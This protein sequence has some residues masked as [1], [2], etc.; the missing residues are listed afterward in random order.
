MKTQSD[1]GQLGC[2]HAAVNAAPTVRT[3][4]GAPAQSSLLKMN[5]EGTGGLGAAR[6]QGNMAAAEGRSVT[7]CLR[8][9]G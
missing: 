2:E 7:Q 6:G 8:Y 3:A 1:T 5:A 9:C 4:P